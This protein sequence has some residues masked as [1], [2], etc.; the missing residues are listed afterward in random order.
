MQIAINAAAADWGMK[1]LRYELRTI[2]VICA[3][4]ICWSLFYKWGWFL[5]ILFNE[6]KLFLFIVSWSFVY[7][8]ILYTISILNPL[9][10][11]VACNC[12]LFLHCLNLCTFV[13]FWTVDIEAPPGIKSAMEM[14]AEAERRKRAKI[15]ESE[16]DIWFCFVGFFTFHNFYF[17]P[18]SHQE[19]IVYDSILCIQGREKQELTLQMD[20]KEF[21]NLRSKRFIHLSS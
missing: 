7:L 20:K 19:N 12:R 15:L 11:W 10:N 5:L 6:M 2:R 13:L 16:G 17:A 14:Q 3:W 8:I 1:C 9:V 4:L 21:C 18:G